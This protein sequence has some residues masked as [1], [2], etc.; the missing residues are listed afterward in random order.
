MKKFI[1]VL[2]TL[3]MA[4][5]LVSVSAFATTLTINEPDGMKNAEYAGYKILNATNNADDT[6][7]FAYTLN[8]K[9]AVALESVTGK[10][11]ETEI[12]KYIANLDADGMRTFANDVYDAI[13]R[14]RIAPDRTDLKTGSNTV[15]EGY[16]LIAQT[17]DAAEGE[18]QSLVMVD[19][20]GKDSLTIES[21]KDTFTV[22]KKVA[23][24]S[25]LICG[26]DG[27]EGHTH[28]A[29]C[30]NWTETNESPIGA[31]VQYKIETQVPA[32]MADY[33]YNAYFIVGDKLGRG[34]D[35]KANTIKVYAG[36]TQLTA[37]KYTVRTATT[38]PACADGYTFQV[39]L[40]SPKAHAGEAVVVEYSAVVNE[41]AKLVLTGNPNEADVTYNPDDDM[42]Y[43]GEPGNGFPTQEQSKPTGKTPKDFTIT[44]VT[45]LK[46]LKV[47]EKGGKL[48]G[49]EFTITG[50]TESTEL[51]WEQKYTKVADGTGEYYLLADKKSYTTQA[52]VQ[53]DYMKAIESETYVGGYVVA[54][55]TDETAAKDVTISNVRYRVATEAD[56]EGGKTIY[57]LVKANADKY[58]ERTPNYDYSEGWEP[59]TATKA[60]NEVIKV[61][62]NGVAK[63]PGLAAGTYHVTESVVPQGYN[64]IDD[65][66]IIITWTAPTAEELAKG[67]AAK[68]TWTAKV[69]E[70]ELSLDETDTFLYAVTVVNQSGT[71]LPSTGG[72]GTTLFYVFGGILVTAAAVLFVTKKRMGIE[73]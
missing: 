9:Y 57:T 34:L 49:A 1:S 53:A 38:S 72:V 65:F 7:K 40:V 67:T 70:T 51:K 27:V 10:N 3:V 24:E 52:P 28:T 2:L 33:T 19:T 5:S 17:S 14:A 43:G 30:Y 44:Y 11:T 23:D 71:E 37:D 68:C 45:G 55:D 61:D 13:V 66:D 64:K 62:E 21:K 60:Y 58:A 32:T 41:N 25:Q 50:I 16:W 39:A 56:F 42:K 59:Q 20:A 15:D 47:D 48:N 29:A 8:D 22:D 46:F 36:D 31:T 73:K 26:K 69:G 18:T 54:A 12:V 4:L 6:T 35:L 63:L